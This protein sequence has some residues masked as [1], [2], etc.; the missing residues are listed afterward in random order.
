MNI[1]QSNMEYLLNF[2]IFD[3]WQDMKRIL[4][5]L[6]AK[7]PRDWQLPVIACQAV[8]EP[9]EKAIP[10]SAALACAQI[11][12]LLVD[13][14]LDD[15]PRGEYHR[16]GSSRASN[17][18][19]AFQAAGMEAL[20]RCETSAPVRLAALDSLNRMMLTTAHGQELDVQNPSDE[21]SYWR[22]VENKSAP[23]FGCAIHLGAI[24]AEASGDIAQNL[25][26]LGRI[27][28][29]MIQIHDDLN[30][31]MAVPANPDWLQK[32]KPLPILFALTVEHPDQAR[33]RELYEDISLGTAL[34][35]A[36]EILIRCGAVSY[37]V[38]QLLRRHRIVQDL[39]NKTPLTDK[40]VVESLIEGMIAPVWKLFET[41]D[42]SP[43]H[44]SM[45]AAESDGG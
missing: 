31:T 4:Q 30:D 12:I 9:T 36:Q 23:F 26:Q 24:L 17:F 3:S 1:Y 19:I 22:I 28:G 18:A 5:Q 8:G 42:I 37:C 43:R 13:D 40:G 6:A 41:L 14:M 33:F 35:E 2:P 44:L 10:A 16:I 15:D 32:R 34:Q 7:Q 27:Y 20:T 21:A 25:E 39:L 29:E 11:S 45:A 38:D